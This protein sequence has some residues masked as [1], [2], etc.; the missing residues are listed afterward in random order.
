VLNIITEVE[1]MY[2]DSVLHIK[3]HLT[4]AWEEGITNFI[5]IINGLW[6]HYIDTWK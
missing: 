2:Q 3:Y 5:Y 6:N 4:T 1:L